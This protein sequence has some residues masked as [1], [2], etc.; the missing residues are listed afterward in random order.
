MLSILFISRCQ[1]TF[2]SIG[3]QR[4]T[5]IP[6]IQAYLIHIPVSGVTVLPIIYG[7][8]IAFGVIKIQKPS[9]LEGYVLKDQ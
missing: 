3:A 4:V 9:I 5:L 1:V 8:Y 6:S 7:L 2:V